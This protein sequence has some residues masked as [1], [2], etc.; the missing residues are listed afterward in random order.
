MK[1]KRK[2]RLLLLALLLSNTLTA[3]DANQDKLKIT[4]IGRFYYDG[5][6]Y[7][8][9]ETKLSNGT[10]MPD[11]RLGLKA[12]YGKFNMKVDI[13]FSDKKVKPK[14]IFLD[15]HIQENAY[16]R[17]G[18]VAPPFGL[19]PWETTS[20]IKF[21]CENPNTYLFGTDRLLNIMFSHYGQRYVLNGCLMGDSNALSN[22]T[23]GR[24]GYGFLADAKY[25]VHQQEKTLLLF[26][27][28]SYIR[29]GNANG[30]NEEGKENPRILNFS[31]PMNTKIE[32][33]KPIVFDIEDVKYQHSSAIYTEARYNNVF[34][35]SEGFF[36]NVKR[37]NGLPSYQA[38]GFYMQGG[39]LLFGDKTYNFDS[40]E[41][42]TTRPRKGL[43]LVA[44]YSYTNMDD[45]SAGINAGKMTDISFASNYYVN[46]HVCIKLNYIY[47]KMGSNCAF[48]AGENVS[49]VQARLQVIF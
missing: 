18:H 39:I 22:D 29:T 33:R 23:E 3:Q 41:K 31:S 1:N 19:E 40:V 8:S 12:N 28:S 11:A 46:N 26:G 42:K 2:S 13:G 36:M 7:F 34:L 15:Y 27:A 17:F 25:V 38:N 16:F 5:A 6:V 10:T 35:Q 21:I 45:N 30:Y 43:E 48:L 24:D 44:R 9:D 37:K 32:K 49:S 14:D 20:S 4:P 47:Q